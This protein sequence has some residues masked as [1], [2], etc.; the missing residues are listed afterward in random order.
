MFRDD[1]YL[2]SFKFLPN[3]PNEHNPDGLPVGF[4]G[5][6][7]KAKERWM[8]LT[9]AA[10]HTTQFDYRG[11]S[12]RVDGGTT[13]TD[14]IAF[15]QALV[16]AVRATV[17][18]DDK[19]C[20]FGWRVLGPHATAEQFE[21]LRAEL[22][23]ALAELAD[24]AA[25]SRPAN[26]TGFGT[27]DA[28]NV[29]M[30]QVN[31]KALDEPSNN[32]VPHVPVSYPSIWNSDEMDKL[33]WNALV[34]NLTL[35]QIGEVIIVFGRAKVTVTDKGLSVKSSADLPGLQSIY[36]TIGTL[37]PPRW[38]EDIMGKLDSAKLE[39]GA[40]SLRPLHCP[41]FGQVLHTCTTPRCQRSTTCCCRKINGRRRSRLA[42]V[43]TMQR[44]LATRQKAAAT[45]STPQSKVFQ[46]SAITTELRSPTK[47][48]GHS[49]NT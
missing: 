38:P 6:D 37:E 8:G 31:A 5:E 11:K 1:D 12:V 23:D 22:K 36:D 29:L 48:A 42:I 19:F 26:A 47:N 4:V 45:R 15:Q 34:H 14:M 44:R 27:R 16:D 25:H 40:K 32:R 41:V 10:C 13:L 35:R 7:S 43:N 2:A 39:L 20:R 17:K 46:T 18:Q 21:E 24:W 3:A 30:N 33:L 28:V 9:C 49:S